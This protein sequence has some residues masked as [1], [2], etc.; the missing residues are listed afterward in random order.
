MFPVDRCKKKINKTNYGIPAG[1]FAP[2]VSLGEKCLEG[3]IGVFCVTDKGKVIDVL[4]TEQYKKQIQQIDAAS[5]S[6]LI[7]LRLSLSECYLPFIDK[8]LKK[9]STNGR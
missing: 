4:Y 1:D 3:V 5:L 2:N 6:E 8:R 9:C 7:L